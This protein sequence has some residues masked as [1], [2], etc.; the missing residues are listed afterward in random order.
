MKKR[1]QRRADR[2]AGEAVAASSAARQTPWLH[3]VLL[4]CA[5]I[6]LAFVVYGPALNGPF[7]LDDLYLPFARPEAE[8][9]K[10]FWPMA[11]R[12]VLMASFRLNY[13]L[14]GTRTTPYH[15]LNVALHAMAAFVVFLIV[16]RLLATAAPDAPRRDLIAALAAGVFLLHPLQAE[17]VAYVASRSEVL[18]TLLAYSA[19][20]VFV[21]RAE[22]A[23][24]WRSVLAVLVLAAAAAGTKEHTVAIAA[25][26]VLTDYFW[27]SGSSVA[28]MRRHW[29][30]YLPIA[31]AL[32]PAALMIRFVLRTAD[33]AGFRMQDLT[34]YEYPFTQFRMIWRYVWMTVV[35]IGQNL[36]PDIAISRGILSEGAIFGLLG[37]V[38][39]TAA[40]WWYRRQAPLIAY[41]FFV[42]LILLAPTSSVLP[43]RDVFAERRIY[44]PFL[45]L[46]LAI[47]G[48]L[49]RWPVPQ[50]ALVGGGAA[51][52]LMLAG[53]TYQR[54]ALWADPILLWEDSVAGSP[55]KVRP[56]FQLAHAYYQDGRCADAARLYEK[57]AAMEEPETR[58]LVNW[59]L[60]LD[61]A[62]QLDAALGPL[63][64]AAE[65]EPTAHIQATIGMIHAKRGD[66]GRA[67]DALTEARR[68]NPKFAIT[69]L[70]EGNVRALQGDPEA[71]LELYRKVI[72]LDPTNQAA[73]QSA[74]QI[75]RQLGANR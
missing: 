25:V 29:R 17:S 56:H 71:A 72:A 22:A 23:L 74:L 8:A 15:V 19:L 39:C 70:Y 48:A 34:W 66:Y 69:Y 12:P 60:A 54:S 68:L 27:Y 36:D 40:A 62:G 50:R 28:G 10:A 75:E 9:G 47:T 57:A 67:L 64:K 16:R 5:A 65:R 61:C 30:F 42:F 37:L 2:S 43:I 11:V 35:P 45:G 51:I 63:R 53:L 32:I 24:P 20:L 14:S 3:P 4:V 52:L 33:T 41:G 38:V 13:E 26:F 1:A 44:L 6:V 58:L 21:S 18:S 46:L 31:V 7:M 49:V 55:N 73:R 59:G